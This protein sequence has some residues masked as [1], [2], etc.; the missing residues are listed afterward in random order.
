MK[1]VWKDV[2]G[3]EG[4][5]KISNTGRITGPRGYRKTFITSNGYETVMFKCSPKNK[6]ERHY[7]HRLVSQHFLTNKLN[8]PCVNHKDF[9]RAN[10]NVN[11]LE[12]CTYSQNSRYSMQHGRCVKSKETLE[13]SRLARKHLFKPIIGINKINGNILQYE[14]MNLCKSDGFDNSSVCCCCKGKRTSHYGYIWN[15]V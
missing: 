1:E 12:W 14:N 7:V 11:N 13:K 5:Y 4:T 2:N 3:W 8:Y 6:I 15:Y 9:D 10:N